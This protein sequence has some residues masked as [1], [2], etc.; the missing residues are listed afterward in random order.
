VRRAEG[1]LGEPLFERLADG[2]RPT[3]RARL[4]AEHAARMEEA[5]HD[6]MR[7]LQGQDTRLSGVLTNNA[8]QLLIAH[9]LSPVLDRF[10]RAHPGIEL[11]ILATNALVDLTRREADVAIRISRNPGDSLKGRRL[12]AQDSASF[13]NADW[14]SRLAA[15]PQT[16][17]D[18]IVY[19]AY[20]D[21]P[22]A[23]TDRFPNQRVRFRFDD[24]VAMTGAAV[25]GLGVVRMPMFLGRA[26]P[27]L[28]Q[29]PV[30][31]P[32]P[33]PDVWVVAHPDVWPSAKVRAF[34]EP[35]VEIA[36]SCRSRFA[37]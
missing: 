5:E 28:Q 16:M 34:V 27:G 22:K 12:L 31:E 15:D 32:Q 9:F 29:V 33:Y 36:K 35:L 18:W 37:A 10:T 20:P 8:P 11:R 30:L 24:M 2:Y 21:V 19:D 4:I 1:A 25:S 23:A 7:R 13:A 14:A 6:L 17:V 26:T 3:A